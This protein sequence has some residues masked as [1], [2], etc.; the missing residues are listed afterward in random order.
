M[1]AGRVEEVVVLHESIYNT[2]C[3]EL[4]KY[5]LVNYTLINDYSLYS[6]NFY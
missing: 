3:L 5:F 6:V 1:V 4:L 2:V